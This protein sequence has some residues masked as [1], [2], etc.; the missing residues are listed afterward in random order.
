VVVD[1][2]GGPP[3]SGLEMVLRFSAWVPDSRWPAGFPDMCCR[4]SQ[5]GFWVG[6]IIGG[7][8]PCELGSGEDLMVLGLQVPDFGPG[9]F[10]LR[11]M[12]V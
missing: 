8:W 11:Q 10:Y 1:G 6:G 4:C 5:P 9:L 3:N 12:L 2:V 7:Q